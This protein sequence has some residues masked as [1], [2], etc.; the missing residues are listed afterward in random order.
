MMVESAPGHAG[1]LRYELPAGAGVAP[2]GEELPRRP[3]EGVTCRGGTL[4]LCPALAGSFVVAVAAPRR[5]ID[6][7]DL[8][9][10]R[11]MQ[12]AC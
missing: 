7:H 10:Y 2:L 4:G 12:P 3:E 9:H 1:A 6:F 11:C 8:L 5:G